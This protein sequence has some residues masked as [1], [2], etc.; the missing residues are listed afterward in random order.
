MQRWGLTGG[1]ASGKSTV[2]AM[3]RELGFKVLEA[4]NLA[5]QL[6]EPGQPAY[7]EVVQRFS[8]EIL[9]ED[10]R[11][12]RATLGA[13]VFAD[14]SKLE[15]LNA[16]VH[17]RVAKAT[18]DQFEVWERDGVRDAAFVEAALIVEAGMHK[19]LDGVVVAWCEPQQQL[20]RLVA[21]GMSPSE[22]KRRIALQMPND[23]KLRYATET[24]DC[25]GSLEETGR[26]VEALA[27]RLKQTASGSPS[28]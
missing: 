17:P 8:R 26:Q 4:D 12:N 9:N 2:A 11:I 27:A 21:R 14:R 6:I 10:G 23:E 28:R 7:N 20:D 19:Q 18:Q 25:S 16:I 15:A 1:I 3:L 5:H 24:I 13:V 22:A